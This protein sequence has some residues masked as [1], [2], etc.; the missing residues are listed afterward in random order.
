M[1]FLKLSMG[2][3][4]SWSPCERD[5]RLR[6]QRTRQILKIQQKH[7]SSEQLTT[8]MHFNGREFKPRSLSDRLRHRS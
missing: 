5:H 8:S 7:F 4:V 3:G 1:L 6:S 2:V